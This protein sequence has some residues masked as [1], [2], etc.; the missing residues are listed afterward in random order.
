MIRKQLVLVATISGLLALAGAVLGASASAHGTP[1]VAGRAGTRHSQVRRAHGRR[2]RARRLHTRERRTLARYELRGISKALRELDKPRTTGVTRHASPQR[3]LALATSEACPG[4]ELA[5]EAGNLEAIR[6][7]TV[8]L[9][10]KQRTQ[11]GERAL[12][13]NAKLQRAAQGHSEN[14]VL[15]N[16]F[17]HYGP[18]GATPS[19]RMRTAGYIYSSRIGYE[20]GENIA[21]G[22][23]YLATP[24]SIVQAWMESPGHRENILNSHYRETAIGVVAQVPAT[25]SEGEAGAI[26]TQDFGVIIT[27]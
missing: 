17:S 3:G 5:P 26:Y 7:A 24:K 23:L 18:D 1:N 21:W 27:G 15:D 10:N 19:Q 8:C 22:T 6:E 25:Y 9:V 12:I 14:M 4:E 13:V 20:I 2:G 16:Y 11:R